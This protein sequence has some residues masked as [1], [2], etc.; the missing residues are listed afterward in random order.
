MNGAKLCRMNL[1][2]PAL[3]C[4]IFLTM[5]TLYARAAGDSIEKLADDPACA[6]G[7]A[8]IDKSASWVTDQQVRLTEIPAPETKEAQRADYFKNLLESAGLKVRVD[9]TGNVIAERP[10]ADEKSVILL[11]AHLDTVFPSGTDVR[12]RRNASRLVAPGIADN[13]AGLAALAGLA[14]ALSESRIHTTKTIVI[15]GDV[16][17]EGE[18]NLR[19]IRALM[20]EYGSRLAAVIAVDGASTE[21][22]T[23]QGIASQRFE[24]SI[25]GPGGHSWSD[26]GAPNPITALSRGIVK[27]SALPMPDEP[28]SSYNFAVIEGGT[29]VN[30]IPAHAAVKVDLRSE[31]EAQ[32]GKMERALRD[33]MQA[34]AKEEMADA[35]GSNDSL[36]VEFRSLGSRPAGKLPDNSPLLEALRSVDRFLGNRSRLER[37]STDANIPLSLGIPAVSLGGGGRGG[38]SHTLSEWYDPTGRE[39]GLKRLFLS[40]VALAGVQS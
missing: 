34:G 38:G 20:E 6:R 32:V 14:R 9:K 33:A 23:T 3:I 21:H 12:I 13:G 19:G 15:A 40:T 16:G 24:I 1:V 28:R 26:F 5:A 17:E 7:L 31:D 22:I 8:W 30:S 37:S 39:L 29:S 2:K 18:G 27:F 11:A 36:Q 10:G 25:T 35:R 4:G